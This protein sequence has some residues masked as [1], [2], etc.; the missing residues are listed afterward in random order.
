MNTEQ[1]TYKGGTIVIGVMEEDMES[2]TCQLDN[3][4]AYREEFSQIKNEK[5]KREFLSARTLLNQA[6]GCQVKVI[7]DANGKPYLEDN[8]FHISITHSKNYAAVI[9]HPEFPVGIDLEIRTEKVK[10]VSKRFL[11]ESEQILFSKEINTAKVEIAWSAKETLYKII[12]NEVRDFA[13]TLEIL[14]FTLNDSGTLHVL[15][16]TGSRIYELQYQQNA[17]YTLVYGVDKKIRL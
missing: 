16:E 9:I 6:T 7:Y 12:G 4:E 5:R 10:T 3:F 1:L 11:N 8:S 15:H 17:H 13:A 2:L 14:P